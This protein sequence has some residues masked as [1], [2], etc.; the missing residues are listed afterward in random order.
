VTDPQVPPPY[1]DQ[2]PPY[3]SQPYQSQPYQSQPYQPVPPEQAPYPGPPTGP[4]GPTEQPSGPIP[5]Q[6]SAT[7]S[8]PYGFDEHGRVQRTKISGVWIGLIAAA[9]VLILLIVF[10]AQNLDTV[11]L[12]FLGFYGKVS[13]GLALLVAAV[14]G[15][16]VAAVP[17][18]V[19]ILQ[20]R[21]ALRR[22]VDHAVT[23]ETK[24]P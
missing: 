6:Q 13:F 9:I 15:V 3:Q 17:G 7:S 18:T 24:H 23:G 21:K 4:T 16:L 22:N 2:P 5:T 19:R 10:I 20:L 11:G 14:A 12:H 8:T 1:P